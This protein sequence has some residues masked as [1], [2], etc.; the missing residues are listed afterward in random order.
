MVVPLCTTQVNGQAFCVIS[1]CPSEVNVRERINTVVVTVLKG[2][3]TARLIEEEFT[4]LLPKS[5]R[6]TTRKVVDNMFTMRFPNAQLIKDW[7]KFN[8]ISLRAVRAK[9]HIEPWNG[10]VGAKA[11]LQHA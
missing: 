6:W 9:V 8:P 7:N 1:N 11:K 10:S 3:I 4:R 5:W 2:N